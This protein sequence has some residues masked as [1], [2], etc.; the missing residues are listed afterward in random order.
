MRGL[1]RAPAERL[2]RDGC[3]ILKL[4]AQSRREPP[5]NEYQGMIAGS[6]LNADLSDRLA[7]IVGAR[8]DRLRVSSDTA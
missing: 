6:E 1:E 2:A 8:L 7:E 3:F 5:Q 4:Q